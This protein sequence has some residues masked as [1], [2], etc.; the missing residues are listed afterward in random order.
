LEADVKAGLD[1]SRWQAHL[2]RLAEESDVRDALIDAG[3]RPLLRTTLG[4]PVSL[5]DAVRAGPLVASGDDPLTRGLASIGVITVEDTEAS[6]ALLVASEPP[7]IF[8][9][10]RQGRVIRRAD[11]VWVVPELLEP[12]AL[13]DGERK[14]V[15]MLEEL[16]KKSARAGRQLTVRVGDFGGP[17]AGVGES[18]VLNGSPSAGVFQRPSS[19]WSW[20]P[21]I[22]RWRCMLVN[23]HHPLFRAQLLAA[24]EEP[25]LAA[26][27]LASAVMHVEA[28]EPETSYRTMLAIAHARLG[29]P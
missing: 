1:P 11:E 8:G 12:D 26:A 16:L 22:L 17:E 7:P 28:I 29:T 3:K 27:G 24:T 14:L 21:P 6:R 19:S 2:A 23:R 25:W 4:E 13:D 10:F 18:L 9:I 20:L 15:G 5:D